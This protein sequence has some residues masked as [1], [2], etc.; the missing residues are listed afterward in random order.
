MRCIG[1]ASSAGRLIGG[2]T[3]KE[4]A[5]SFTFSP[6]KM[7]NI[8]TLNDSFVSRHIWLL[9]LAR[10]CE[11]AICGG[12]AAAICKDN[13]SYEPADLDLVSTKANA[14]RFINEVNHFMLQ[15]GVHYRVL[16]N[17]QND[18]VPPPAV[19]HFRVL[20]PFWVPVCLFVLP[21]EKFRYYRIQEGYL[22]QLPQDIKEAAD[23]MT[24]RDERER[25]ASRLERHDLE[26]EDLYPLPE[27]QWPKDELPDNPEDYD[28]IPPKEV[29]QDLSRIF[30][31][32][33]DPDFDQDYRRPL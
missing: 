2:G 6:T 23:H 33:L 21:H 16:V 28:P 11:V 18:F 20:A 4:L 7:K 31:S 29:E 19:A 30:V 5:G 14:L 26:D 3:L 12:C 32:K 15:R 10:S 27:D 1:D 24:E 25:I 17:S 22:I 9:E 8:Y 13:R